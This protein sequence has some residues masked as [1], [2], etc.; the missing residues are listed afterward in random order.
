MTSKSHA[1]K[2]IG[3]LGGGQL[4]RMMILKAHDLGLQAHVLSNHE[5]DP[6]AQ[7]TRNWVQ[8]S[9]DSADD[10]KK[11]L[12][13]VDLV[14]FESEFYDPKKLQKAADLNPAQFLP[15]LKNLALLQDRLLQKQSLENHG[16]PTARFISVK[17]QESFQEA[18]HFFEHKVVFKKRIGGYDGYGTIILKS[19]KDENIVH[20]KISDQ[21]YFFIAEEFI[22]FKKELSLVLARNQMG[23]IVSY[24]LIET[25]QINSK[26]DWARGPAKHRL[27]GPLLNQIKVYLKKIDYVGVI[28][29]EIFETQTELL[30]NEVAPR[31]HNTGHFSLDA[32]N[33]DQFT[34]HL[35]CLLGRTLP[36]PEL[37]TKSFCMINLVGQ[38]ELP[39][40]LS[41]TTKGALHWYGKSQNRPGRKMGHINYCG[42]HADL[43]LKLGLNERKRILR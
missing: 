4:A 26:C 42:P 10:L 40:N 16:L 19:K 34:L 32:C 3:I 37:K 8:G 43:L 17:N 12:E 5:S 27:L 24:P 9:P 35:L 20:Q 14:T 39:M 25:K 7:V 31:V 18:C 23:Q 41:V 29:F 11:F 1:E 21:D 6:A 13:K 30:I 38:S 15:H 2:T 33:V 36:Q 28:A 22:P